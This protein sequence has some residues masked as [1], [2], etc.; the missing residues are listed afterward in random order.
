M[1]STAPSDDFFRKLGARA[2]KLL[3]LLLLR[4]RFP[5]TAHDDNVEDEDYADANH[6]KRIRYFAE[7]KQVAHEGVHEPDVP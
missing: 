2:S 4:G 6:F 7:D 1:S 3:F 5:L